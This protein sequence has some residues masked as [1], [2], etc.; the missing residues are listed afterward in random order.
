VY[1]CVFRFPASLLGN[2]SIEI[3]KIIILSFP[4]QLRDFGKF[5]LKEQEERGDGEN[6]MSGKRPSSFNGSLEKIR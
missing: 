2:I 5:S 6:S 1:F 3:Y 4:V